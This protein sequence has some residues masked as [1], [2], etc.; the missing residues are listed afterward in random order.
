MNEDS[1]LFDKF[2]MRSRDAFKEA[3]M[4]AICYGQGLLHIHANERGDLVT[5]YVPYVSNESTEREMDD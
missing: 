2:L 3:W 5:E 4:D 1:E